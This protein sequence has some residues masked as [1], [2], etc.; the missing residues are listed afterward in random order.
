MKVENLTPHALTIYSGDEPVLV[1]SPSGVVARCIE[2]AQPQG[3]VVFDGVA[4][5]IISKS[6]G[7]VEN[8]ADPEK[9]KVNFVSALVAQAAFALGRTDVFCPGDP[10]RNG[11]GQIIGCRSLCCAPPS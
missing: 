5:P 6:F 4:I 7:A 8:L 3:E 2:T 11:E 1:I 9:D 10:V